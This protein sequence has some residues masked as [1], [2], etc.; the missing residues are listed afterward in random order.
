MCHNLTQHEI[1]ILNSLCG[2]GDIPNTNVLFFG[3]EEGLGGDTIQYVV[4]ERM[5][6]FPEELP[7][8]GNEKMNGHYYQ[9]ITGNSYPLGGAFL[10]YCSRLML[11]LSNPGGNWC[12]PMGVDNLAAKKIRDYHKYKLFREKQPLKSGLFELRPLPR[13]NEGEWPYCEP[14]IIDKHQ[15]LTAF[16]CTQDRGL[17]AYHT[18]LRDER[19]RI[20]K[21]IFTYSS[22]KTFIGV[23]AREFKKCFLEEMYPNIKFRI[24]PLVDVSIYYAQT[25]ISGRDV[26]IYLCPFFGH[27]GTGLLGLDDL[28]VLGDL[29][30]N[31][32]V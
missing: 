27:F 25:N 21:N 9:D 8:D 15:Y 31:N 26:R 24:I 13:A 2:T 3:N 18:N 14:G 7:V 22:A 16:S 17:D 19:I 4:Q 20:L 32:G 6:H 5:N 23:G 28:C 1:D 10:N 29:I 12:S 11:K 30:V